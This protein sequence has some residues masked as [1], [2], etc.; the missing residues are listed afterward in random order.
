MSACHLIT[1]IAQKQSILAYVLLLPFYC[2]RPHNLTAYD[3]SSRGPTGPKCHNQYQ[4][5][6]TSSRIS[7]IAPQVDHKTVAIGAA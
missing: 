1:R 3:T 7:I 6:G 2:D 4:E 5:P